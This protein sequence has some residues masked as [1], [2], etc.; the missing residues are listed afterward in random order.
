MSARYQPCT[1]ARQR[2]HEQLRRELEARKAAA[3]NQTDKSHEAARNRR[4]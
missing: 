4:H 3:L 2:K 1:R